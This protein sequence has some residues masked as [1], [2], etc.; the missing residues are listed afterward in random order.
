MIEWR[1]VSTIGSGDGD[2]QRQK[3]NVSC[4]RVQNNV[5]VHLIETVSSVVPRDSASRVPP[6]WQ[7]LS[8]VQDRVGEERKERSGELQSWLLQRRSGASFRQ[9]R[10]LELGLEEVGA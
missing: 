4:L 9:A 3:E 5:C 2:P 10:S 6:P 8:A 1:F 7:S